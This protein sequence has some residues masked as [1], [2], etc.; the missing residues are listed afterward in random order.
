MGCCYLLGIEIGQVRA[1]TKKLMPWYLTI[2]LVAGPGAI[3]MVFN[4]G[5]TENIMR[6]N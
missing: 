6:G 1:L 3:A 5:L 4:Y 2:A